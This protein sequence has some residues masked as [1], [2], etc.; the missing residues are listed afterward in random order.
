MRQ[1]VLDE[2][3]QPQK[4]PRQTQVVKTYQIVRDAKTYDLYTYPDYKHYQL[5]YDKR[6]IDPSTFET[7]P[8]GYQAAC[9]DTT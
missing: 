2:I 5:V 4:E 3:Q 9:Q 8:D 1:N 7:Y 6:V